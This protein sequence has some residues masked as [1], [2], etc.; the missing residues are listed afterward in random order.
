MAAVGNLIVYT[1]EPGE[2]VELPSTSTRYRI[3]EAAIHL[4][5]SILETSEG[6][7]SLA[8]VAT[9][10]VRARRNRKR[11]QQDVYQG[12]LEDMP[13]WIRRFLASMRENFPAVF[14]SDE[15]EG[16]AEA[17]RLEWANDMREYDA[18]L[19]GNLYLS[20]VLIDNMVYAR[21]NYN[22]AGDSYSMFKFQMGI[23]IAHEIVHLLTGF[24][25]GTPRP[26]TPPSIT[27]DPYGTRRRGEAGRLWESVLL[28]GVV[29]FW[30]SNDD[31]LGVRQAGMPFLFADGRR[32]TDGYQVS[33]NYINEIINGGKSRQLSFAFVK[34]QSL[35]V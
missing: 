17:E 15:V 26:D 23:S 31:P 24:V 18:G 1:N 5:L 20:R 29:E 13:I 8:E 32:N 7:R 30:S 9:A 28:G 12:S 27:L 16:E 19:A 22:V 2:Y 10:I 21:Q 4:G 34:V 3:V 33:L 14:L 25:S 35:N 6:R 11:P